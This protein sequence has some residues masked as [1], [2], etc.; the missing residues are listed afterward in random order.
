MLLTYHIVVHSEEEGIVGGIAERSIAVTWVVIEV[1]SI[2]FISKDELK[3]VALKF[4]STKLCCNVCS[5][6]NDIITDGGVHIIDGLKRLKVSVWV[7]KCCIQWNLHGYCMIVTAK[8]PS[9]QEFFCSNVISS[10][11]L[12]NL[13]GPLLSSGLLKTTINCRLSGCSTLTSM[14]LSGIIG[15]GRNKTTIIVLCINMHNYICILQFSIKY[16]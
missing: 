13:I 10:S 15:A 12:S 2:L 8:I 4:I 5:S 3:G 1:K 9:N 7:S 6:L 14:V 11:L 16:E